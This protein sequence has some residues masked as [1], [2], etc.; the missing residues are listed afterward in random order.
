LGE[1]SPAVAFDGTQLYKMC[2]EHRTTMPENTACVMYLRGF[3]EGLL[4][5]TDPH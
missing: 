3:V 1:A 2:S 5:V 4:V